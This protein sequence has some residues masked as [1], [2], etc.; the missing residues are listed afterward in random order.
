MTDA[1]EF[2]I[3]DEFVLSFP[4]RLVV[5]D[6]QP[7]GV[8]VGPYSMQIDDNIC[9]V[10]FTDD[11]LLQRHFQESDRIHLHGAPSVLE[12]DPAQL[13]SYL[14]RLDPSRTHVTVDPKGKSGFKSIMFPLQQVVTRL[15]EQLHEQ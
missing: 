3:D 4:V 8:C 5:F 2:P 12:L 6:L 11:D 10:L 15:R 13:I 9:V 7:D 14:V 1:I